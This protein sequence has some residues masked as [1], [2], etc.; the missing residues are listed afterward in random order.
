MHYVND[1]IEQILLNR[2]DMTQWQTGV[3]DNFSHMCVAVDKGTFKLT[4]LSPRGLVE[5]RE[6]MTEP[7]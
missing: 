7:F 4:Q 1:S 5:W 6:L 3:M 2:F